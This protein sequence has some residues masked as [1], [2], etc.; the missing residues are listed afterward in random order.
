[1][2]KSDHSESRERVRGMVRTD[3]SCYRQI[4]QNQ[5]QQQ[6]RFQFILQTDDSNSTVSSIVQNVVINNITP[7]PSA[8]NFRDFALP[9]S[10]PPLVMRGQR[11]MPGGPNFINRR[12]F[13][14]QPNFMPRSDFMNR[15]NFQPRHSNSVNP[16]FIAQPN[17]MLQ[18]NLPPVESPASPPPILLKPPENDEHTKFLEVR[19]RV[20]KIVQR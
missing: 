8:S 13:I 11:I 17:F 10:G 20:R 9:A 19:R 5:S 7:G 4:S 16:N 18:Q 12:N 3:E 14:P 15:A 6:A 1:M 2:H